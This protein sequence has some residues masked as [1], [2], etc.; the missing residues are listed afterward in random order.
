VVFIAEERESGQRRAIAFVEV[1]LR[2]HAD[3]CDT[4]RPLRIPRGL[5]C[6]TADKAAEP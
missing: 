3:G 1:G 6:R 4:A 2:S 5:V